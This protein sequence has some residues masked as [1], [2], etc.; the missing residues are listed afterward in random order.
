ME[1]E[2]ELG[3]NWNRSWNMELSL[4]LIWNLNWNKLI[5]ITEAPTIKRKHSRTTRT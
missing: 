1:R 2:L 4:E 5:I 3:W